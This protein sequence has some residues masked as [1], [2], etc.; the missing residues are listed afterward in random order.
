MPDDQKVN[1]QREK[2]SELLIRLDERT[3]N[4]AQEISSMNKK[5]SENYITRAEFEK[6]IGRFELVKAE[7]NLNKKILFG[8]IGLILG[9]VF[10]ALIYTVINTH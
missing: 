7:S 5:F 6:F 10:T 9:I 3:L 8:I 4:M 1:E 2:N